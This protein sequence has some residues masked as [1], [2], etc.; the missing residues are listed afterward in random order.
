M[1]DHTAIESA[2]RRLQAALDALESAAERRM[3][4]GARTAA[5]ADQMHALDAD[6]ARLAS[7][8]DH[9]VARARELERTNR[10]VAERID[11]AM[12]AVRGVIE[13]QED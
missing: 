7:D 5:L 2:T 12:N 1:T 10:E 13:A 8:L 4:A 9:A 6:R 11:I 3:E